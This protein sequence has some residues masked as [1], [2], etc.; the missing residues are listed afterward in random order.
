MF[1]R[2]L[3]CLALAGGAGAAVADTVWMKN[4]DRLT[5]RVVLLERGK[6]VIETR[7]GGDIQLKWSEVATLETD[8]QLLIRNG[9]RDKSVG[10][11]LRPAEQGQ[12]TL[13]QGEQSR[14][15]P[16]EAISQIIAPK[17]FVEDLR[18]KGNVD[19]GLNYKR[20]EA[21]TDDY[22]V[23]VNTQASHGQWRHNAKGGYN[24]AYTN[25][26]TVTN[27]WNA[28]YAIDRFI[29]DQWFWQNRLS[30]RRDTIE[31]VRRQRSIGTGPGYQF[32][33]NELGAFSLATLLNHS[34]YEFDTGTSNSFQQVTLRW[35]YN[36]Y[37]LGKSFELFSNGE[38]GKPLSNIADYTL[39]A[40]AGLR[41][42]VTDWA[43]LNMRAEKDV[44]SGAEGELDETSYH[45]GFGIGW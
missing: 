20:G 36:R 10:Y 31:E 14:V 25:G 21:D 27:N 18:F 11:W 44:V 12:V 40:A 17:P 6:L 3:L 16:L 29:D 8:R 45:V 30:Y 19:L 33:D 22:K 9:E 24:R 1:S 41:Y 15:E 32:W 26:Q 39:A 7:Y 13:V 4:G 23:R 43:S 35:D 38:V 28:E 37:L 2:T 5:G 34:T 42:K